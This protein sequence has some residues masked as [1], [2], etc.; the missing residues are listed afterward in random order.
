MGKSIKNTNLYQVAYSIYS[1]LNE[2]EIKHM[3]SLDFFKIDKFFVDKNIKT[4][5]F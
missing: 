3:E 1:Y 5:W 4:I 2:D